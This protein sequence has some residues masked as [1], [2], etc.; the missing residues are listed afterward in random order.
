MTVTQ[1]DV[2]ARAG[3]AARTVSNVVNDFAYVSADTRRRV[4]AAIEELGYRP[5]RA[6]QYLRTGRSGTI[7]VMLPELDVGYFAEIGRLLVEEASG[8]GYTVLI[9]QTLGERDREASVIDS[10]AGRQ[11]DGLVIS[12][13]SIGGDDLLAHAGSVP[14]VLLGEHLVESDLDHVAIDNVAATAQAVEH[15]VQQGRRSVAFIGHMPGGRLNMADM[16]V[17]GYR[18]TVERNNIDFND[19]LIRAVR[20]YHRSHGFDAVTELLYDGIHFDGLFCANDLLA[21]GAMRALAD[22]GIRVPHDVAV[23]GFDD[24]D[25]GRFSVPRLSTISPDKAALARLTLDLLIA[26][27]GGEEPRNRHPGAGDFSLVVRESSQL[28]AAR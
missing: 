19:R 8:R 15:L 28:S 25:E 1:A 21:I 6:A 10:F 12:P 27:I 13:I 2:A 5:N 16:R 23:I 9:A 18:Y 26:R 7:G 11:P 24:L 22:H 17:T 3:V 14:V 4:L 20:G